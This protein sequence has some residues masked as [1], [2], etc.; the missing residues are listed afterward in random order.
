[1][2]LRTS[3][4]HHPEEDELKNWL[5]NPDLA[6]G[7]TSWHVR[8]P[9]HAALDPAGTGACPT[10]RLERAPGPGEP[11]VWYQRVADLPTR[12]QVTLTARVHVAEGEAQLWVRCYCADGNEIEGRHTQPWGL[13]PRATAAE[14]WQTLEYDFLVPP[15]TAVVEVGGAILFQGCAWFTDF[16]L[17]LVPNDEV[18]LR[19]ALVETLIRQG[20]LTT[21]ASRRAFLRV[22][23]HQFLPKCTLAEVYLDDAIVTR[24]ADQE[25]RQVGIS[26]SS[27]PAAMS[28]MLGQLRLRP[29]LR[30]L[31]I[32]AGTG[33]NAALLADIV[34]AEN[35]VSIDLDAEI[36]AEA[37][38]HLNSAGFHA[39]S[40]AVAD[41]W[42]GY[43]ACAPY[44]R[45]IV[46]VGVQD[47]AP[48]WVEQLREGG[49]LVAPLSFGTAQFTPAFRKRGHKL[50]S[51]RMSN[52]TFMD[53]RGKQPRRVH[54]QRGDALTVLHDALS[55]AD[56]TVLDDLLDRPAGTFTTPELADLGPAARDFF[57]YFLPFAHPLAL[58]IT[59]PRLSAYGI[60]GVAVAIANLERHQ[61]V[62]SGGD[63]PGVL[64]QICFGGSEIGEEFR[65][66]A[67]EWLAMGRPGLDRLVMTACPRVT[68]PRAD[69]LPPDRWMGLVE[70]EHTW[71]QCRYRK[72]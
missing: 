7:M 59:D 51:E 48:A 16:V 47:L 8:P 36:V 17:R 22:P 30:V 23:R 58:R 41:G 62:V 45:I 3:P 71:F 70:K 44:D 40:V 49:V 18:T 29:R 13:I 6:Q 67:R 37:R 27:Q 65:R 52:C 42:D 4:H 53:L 9:N 21:A 33:Y 43:P 32:G 25:G 1:M 19:T 34:G 46:T 63:A 11:T 20:N 14:G 26:S 5:V 54:H 50:V 69:L 66:L 2:A 64:S 56:L 60:Q 15:D 10:A 24:F 38:A 28:L 68:Y 72:R 55:E 31:E 39:V 35:V 57:A 61:L 12:R